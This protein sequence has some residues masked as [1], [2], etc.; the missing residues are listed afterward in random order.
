MLT[1][2][3]INGFKSFQN[4]EMH[5]KPFTIIAGVN[6]SGKSNLFD[7]LKFL[8]K[9]AETDNL[10]RAIKDQRGEFRELF[11][12]YSNN[13]YASEIE[14][15]VEM[16]VDKKVKD[17]WGNETE[18][19]YT[20]LKY[21]LIIVRFENTNGIEDLKVKYERLENLKHQEDQWIKIIP[22]NVLED[23][24]PKVVT[25]KRG[26]PYIDTIDENGI[27]TVIVPQDG[28][29]GGNKRR[30]PLNN[31]MRTV[32]SSFDTIDFPHVLAAKEEMKS[33]RF[34]EMN[35]EDLRLPTSKSTGED[36]LS[37]SGKNL[38]AV[39]HRIKLEDSYNLKEISRELQSFLP[40]FV[41]ADVL[42]DLENKLFII[43]LIDRDKKEYTSRVLS[44]GTLR[45]LALCIL[46][47]DDSYTGLLCFEEPENG[48]H[49]F[50]IESM[51][52]LLKELSVDFSYSNSGLRQVIINTHSPVLVGN[53]LEKYMDN[54]FV[55]VYLSQMVS[56]KVTLQNGQ[57]SGINVTIMVSPFE[58]YPHSSEVGGLFHPL[59]IS[60]KMLH[61]KS[62]VNKYLETV[63]FEG[64]KEKLV[65]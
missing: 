10:K 38:A 54:P 32:L 18:L 45:I 11:T 41:S 36:F 34:L 62:I 50:R 57:T 21:E 25:G 44:E 42:D 31:A 51:A 40:N 16:L 43:K 4:F 55:E 2:L 3:K 27:P 37:P 60:S 49:P 47:Y 52:K 61:A 29:Q 8:G 12:Q 58:E 59:E 23:W 53:I 6:A 17:A 22:K 28:V 33:W 35:P 15:C 46:K 20:R 19:K 63:E 5:F 7:A 9:L 14:F 64:I 24:R 13:Q 39:L 56:R 26:I 1:Y 48:I 30:F 65:R